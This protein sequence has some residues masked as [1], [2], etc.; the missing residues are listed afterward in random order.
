MMQHQGDTGHRGYG[1][2]SWAEFRCGDCGK[3]FNAKDYTSTDSARQACDDHERSH[4]AAPS[5][6]MRTPACPHCGD[7]K[8]VE[9]PDSDGDYHCTYPDCQDHGY[10]KPPVCPECGDAQDVEGPDGDGE[11]RCSYPDC[12]GQYFRHNRAW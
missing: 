6:R 8:D 7:A 11:Y 2:A 1:G 10:F 3:T 9:G 12:S 4:K 5:H